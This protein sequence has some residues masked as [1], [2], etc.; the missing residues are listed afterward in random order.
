MI[1]LKLT[2]DNRR[3][4]KDGTYP[5]V[6]R[7]NY[8][9][10]T[11][12]IKTG[13]SAKESDWSDNISAFYLNPGVDAEI[14]ISI[15]TQLKQLQKELGLTVIVLAHVPKIASGTPIHINHLAG[16]KSLA[17]FADSVFFIAKSRQGTNIRYLKHVKGRNEALSEN[18][19]SFEIFSDEEKVG[20]KFIG[21]SSENEHLFQG[22]A[23]NDLERIEEARKLRDA[24][25]TLEE[26]GSIFGVNKSTVSR[27]LNK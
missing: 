18:V 5:L 7:I 4:K 22:V 23:D 17:N 25:R 3:K 1:S 6:F 15:M 11:R 8:N 20:F 9:G 19:H 21:E 2:P 13:Y 12:D 26:I 24:G 27:W 16:S 14:A 10:Q